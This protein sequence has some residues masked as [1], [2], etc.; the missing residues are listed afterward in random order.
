MQ[1]DGSF[2]CF[3]CALGGPDGI[4]REAV[5]VVET[6]LKGESKFRCGVCKVLYLHENDIRSLVEHLQFPESNIPKLWKRAKQLGAKEGFLFKHCPGG[7]YFCDTHEV[8]E[9]GET[10]KEGNK[11]S[12]NTWTVVRQKIDAIPI[13]KCPV[14]GMEYDGCR[15][16][17]QREEIDW[18]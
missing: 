12:G 16:C 17:V 13:L 10:R 4:Y 9:I 2:F 15:R 5:R 7:H 1:T 14:C 8:K 18:C 11:R 3:E 6:T